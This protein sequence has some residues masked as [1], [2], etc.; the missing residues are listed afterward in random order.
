MSWAQLLKRVFDIASGAGQ[1]LIAVRILS[2][3]SRIRLAK[4]GK[5]AGFQWSKTLDISS[6]NGKPWK[7]VA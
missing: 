2:E 5:T 6:R 3:S 1:R 4:T 7:G